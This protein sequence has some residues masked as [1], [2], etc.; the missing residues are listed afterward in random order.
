MSDLPLLPKLL[1]VLHSVPLWILAGFAVAGYA[2]IFV[3]SFGGIDVTEFKKQWGPWCW[4]DAI[5][6]SV[7]AVACAIDLYV[8]YHRARARRRRQREEHRY[9]KIY[10][11]L[12]AELM[13]IHITTSGGL[14]APYFSQR[15]AHAWM[16]LTGIKRKWP[17][18][19]RAWKALFDKI[20]LH[21]TGEVDYGGIFPIDAIKKVIHAN[22]VYCDDQL[23]NL[24][25]R[26]TD[27][28]IND[29]IGSGDLSTED[30]RLYDHIVEQR[31]WLRKYL[32]R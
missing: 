27:T 1:S 32:N 5:F 9:F 20:P 2:V 17:A 29:S 18:T 23:L 7:L 26:A 25:G 6:F 12:F 19:K 22:L 11:P 16:K 15:V 10:A 24:M 21:P 14:G 30:V 31:D 28:R 4:L 8:K 13:K 3:P